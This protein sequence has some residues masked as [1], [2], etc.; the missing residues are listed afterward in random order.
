[1]IIVD[2]NIVSG[3]RA[4]FL[5]AICIP[6]M[7]FGETSAVPPVV[8]APPPTKPPHVLV[9]G[10]EIPNHPG[11]LYYSVRWRIKEGLNIGLSNTESGESVLISL[12]GQKAIL[13]EGTQKGRS[14]SVWDSFWRD[15]SALPPTDK[16][17]VELTI[18]LRPETWR[19]YLDNRPVC[20]FRPPFSLPVT[21]S[22][23]E[24]DLPADGESEPFFQKIA[25]FVFK[26]NFLAEANAEDRLGAWQIEAGS[27]KLH[28]VLDSL[29][30][31]DEVPDRS[32]VMPQ[33]ELSPNFYSLKGSGENALITSGY[34]FYDAYSF[35]AA[36]QTAPAEMGVVFMY[37]DAGRHYSFTLDM[38]GDSHSALLRLKRHAGGGKRPETMA[39]ARTELTYD[40]WVKLRVILGQDRIRCFVDK[41]M[42]FD[43]E[44]QLP[45]GGRFGLC[46]KSNSGVRFDDVTV[47]SHKDPDLRS[48]SDLRRY[49]IRELGNFLPAK[50]PSEQEGPSAGPIV[51]RPPLKNEVQQ[52]VVGSV[53]HKPHVFDARFK[54]LSSSSTAGLLVGYVSGNEPYYRFTSS[55]SKSNILVAVEKVLTGS[56][57]TVETCRYPSGQDGNKPFTLMA[58]ACSGG[59]LRLYRNNKLVVVLP[60][61]AEADGASG[62]YVAPG[63]HLE[64]SDLGYRFERDDVYR[65]L[66]EKNLTFLS[67]PYMRHWSS[68]EGEWITGKDGLTWYKGDFFGRFSVR[69]PFA[70]GSEVNFGVGENSTTGMIRLAVDEGAIH[71][72][73]GLEEKTPEDAIGHVPK[74]GLSTV[75]HGTYSAPCYT[76]HYE[77]YWIWITSGEKLLFKHR[78]WEPLEGRRL[79]IA[80]FELTQLKF[81]S[82]TRYKVKDY[83]FTQSLHDWTVNGGEWEVVNRFQCQPRWSH[84]IGQSRDTVAAL[85]AKYMFEGDFCVEMYAGL[86][87]GWYERIGDLNMTVFNDGTS[88]GRGYTVTC[89]GWDRNHSQLYTRLF[90]NGKEIHRSDKYTVPRTREGS[91]RRGYNPLV[92][93]GRP[94]HGAWYFIKFRRVGEKLEYYFDNELVF[95][96]EDPN[97]LSGGSLGIWTFMN[98]MVV[99]RVKIAAEEISHK[100][101]PVT[102]LALPVAEA[103]DPEPEKTPWNTMTL[104]KGYRPWFWTW[105]G[106]WEV[107]DPVGRGTLSWKRDKDGMPYFVMKNALGSGSMFTRCKT[108]PSRVNY[109]AGWRFLIKRTPETRINFHF[110]VGNGKSADSFKPRRSFFHRISG[111]DFSEGPLMMAGETDVPATKTKDGEWHAEGE[112]IPVEVWLPA[113]AYE[114]GGTHVK[115]EGFGNAQPSDVLQG[116]TGNGPGEGYAVKGFAEV[117]YGEPTLSLP[118][119]A[120]P[121]KQITL[122]DAVS[123]KPLLTCGTAEE[124]NT[125][126]GG[127][128]TTGYIRTLLEIETEPVSVVREINWVTLSDQP[129]LNCAWHDERPGQFVITREGNFSDPRLR[130]ESIRVNG[131]DVEV[132]EESTSS[133]TAILPVQFTFGP[134]NTNTVKVVLAT[135]KEEYDFTLERRDTTPNIPP[136]LLGMDGLTP[137]FKNFEYDTQAEHRN[138]TR[139]GSRAHRVR[140]LRGHKERGGYFEVINGG[141]QS[142][143]MLDFD[144][145]FSMAKYP[146]LQMAYLGDPM[147]NVSI[148]FGVNNSAHF[149]EE[150]SRGK[151]I[152]GV[153]PVTMNDTWQT[154]RGLVSDVMIGSTESKFSMQATEIKIGSLSREADQTGLFSKILLDDLILGPAVSDSGQLTFT[155]WFHDADGIAAVE[156]AVCTGPTD[157]SQL[158]S[159]G[160]PV[161]QD[162]PPGVPI[163]P[164]IGSLPD[165]LCRILVRARDR[166]GAHSRVNEIPFLLDREEVKGTCKLLSTKGIKD[167]GSRLL[168]TFITGTGSPLDADSLAMELNGTPFKVTAG[169]GRRMVMAEDRVH[170]SLNWPFV[171]RETIDQMNDGDTAT[172]TFT[173]IRDGAGNESPPVSAPIT[174]NYAEDKRGPALLEPDYP[175]SVFWA[176]NWDDVRVD[177]AGLQGHDSPYTTIKIVRNEEEG[178]YC[179]VEMWKGRGRVKKEFGEKEWMAEKFPYV[180]LRL[181]REAMGGDEPAYFAMT[182]YLSDGQKLSYRIG[183]SSYLEKSRSKTRK[184]KSYRVKGD[185]SPVWLPGEWTPIILDLH[186]LKPSSRGAKILADRAILD[187][188]WVKMIMFSAGASDSKPLKMHLQS[189][190]IFSPSKTEDKVSMMAYDAS[191]IGDYVSSFDQVEVRDSFSP[192]AV[193]DG[194]GPGTWITMRAR[195]KAG[196]LSAPMRFPIVRRPEPEPPA[197]EKVEQPAKESEPAVKE[198][199]Q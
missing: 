173:G 41:S 11:N 188:A 129:S 47:A 132:I 154:W 34:D 15:L 195:D 26:D 162:Y 156:L 28:S 96:T 89:S 29:T 170:L 108:I 155:P 32:E 143:L 185:D 44:T 63:S 57:E 139:Y 111:D 198:P 54:P 153:E 148:S 19:I 109:V 163:T 105:A 64:I 118:A 180:G 14:R 65:N 69:L 45:G 68:P 77:D 75:Q 85:W 197:S 33:A 50:L 78:L 171:F 123:R 86:R 27:W 5:V 7:L 138:E 165:G 4:I 55:Q 61:I 92:P 87:H 172:V 179:R 145:S 134:Q 176:S 79:R 21:L 49:V 70:A 81:S 117:C 62:L 189:L 97:P 194:Q 101:T 174:M 30:E 58:D 71:V 98:S 140:H 100:I 192:V 137:F 186:E 157:I 20:S 66:F 152:R 175:D 102:P 116:L 182:V 83:L 2:R 31:R 74:D 184:S 23:P 99:A 13:G 131:Q 106:N 141:V 114:Q 167:N 166:K 199:G 93:S 3:A 121:L 103:G 187:G 48:M 82:V 76:V 110:S 181:R 124:F 112:W 91:E 56:I 90:R 18:K 94:V 125:A 151:V 38:Q 24:S 190:F 135:R 133:I 1:M 43:V 115:V 42:V 53:S 9:S 35:E 10:Y 37:A 147:A 168:A 120:P 6:R 113:A 104:L 191:G 126:V 164:Q 183:Y 128:E 22:H 193:L 80:G 95:S 122:R 17:K 160:E 119:D 73:S 149:S 12:D 25:D 16:D 46:V 36:M 60:E 59:G 150:N 146:I 8:Q 127:L 67:D 39:A 51:L 144:T 142:R 169:T 161:W 177:D 84:M 178:A 196:N 88:P 40:Q 159:P 136:V 107:D 72:F 158:T 130:W 52:L